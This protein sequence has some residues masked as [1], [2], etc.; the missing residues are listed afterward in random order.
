MNKCKS[1]FALFQVKNYTEGLIS[2]FTLLKH[3][4]VHSRTIEKLP[5]MPSKMKNLNASLSALESIFT[6]G[7]KEADRSKSHDGFAVSH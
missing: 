2:E 5:D 6:V 1:V 7:V 3:L 4:E